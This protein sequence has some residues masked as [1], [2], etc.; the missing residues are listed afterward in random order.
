MSDLVYFIAARRDKGLPSLN[1]AT[2]SRFYLSYESARH[3][4]DGFPE[5]LQAYH[6]VF[7]AHALVQQEVTFEV[8]F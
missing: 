8:P 1:N 7:T 4:L 5:S 6:A 2:N 3:A